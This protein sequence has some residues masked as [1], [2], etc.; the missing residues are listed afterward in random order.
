VTNRRLVGMI[1]LQ[2]LTVGFIG[3]AL[4]TGMAAAF[5]E[6]FSRQIATRGIVLLWQN[7]VGVGLLMFL[8]VIAA[9][10]LSIRR[11][12]ILEPAAVFRG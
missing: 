9:S 8:V 12:L 11:V 3:Y 7:V 4:G 6:F 2:A 10:L 5:F 1:L